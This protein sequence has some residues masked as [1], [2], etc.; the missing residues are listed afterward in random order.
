MIVT[1]D[2]G[3]SFTVD[4]ATISFYYE[5]I[6]S[7]REQRQSLRMQ[8]LTTAKAVPVHFGQRKI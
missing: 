3:D 6:P 4:G 5:K 7:S 1:V 8:A 2:G